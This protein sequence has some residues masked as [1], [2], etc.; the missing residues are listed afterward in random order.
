MEAARTARIIE[1]NSSVVDVT[2]A[3]TGAIN[4][5]DALKAKL[6]HVVN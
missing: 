2:M 6:W 4:R 3:V 1:P 5:I